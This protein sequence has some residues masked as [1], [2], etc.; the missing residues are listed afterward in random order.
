MCA[1]DDDGANMRNVREGASVSDLPVQ[2]HA[3]GYDWVYTAA[4]GRHVALRPGTSDAQVWADTFTGLYAVPHL[5]FTPSRV[6]DLGG[7]IGLTAAHYQ[8]LW[9]DAEVAAVEMDADCCAMIRLNAPGIEVLE[10]AVTGESMWGSYCTTDRAEAFAFEP[11]V[12]PHG[13][14]FKGVQGF[15]LR[16]IIEYALGWPQVDFLKA[17]IEGEEHDLF[18]HGDWAPLVRTALFELHPDDDHPDDSAALVAAGIESLR[19]LGFRAMHH[20]RHPRSVYAWRW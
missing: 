2:Y 9:P 8:A 6:L 20:T 18:A 17:D 16:S 19:A 10:A 11:G 15:A 5:D 4:L 12:P 1:V 7:N 13:S 14:G 3:D